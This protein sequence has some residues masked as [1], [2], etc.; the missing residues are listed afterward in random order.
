MLFKTR[1]T[2]RLNQTCAE[3]HFFKGK[4]SHDL[5]FLEISKKV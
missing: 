4:V 5:T 3:S 1:L 2:A